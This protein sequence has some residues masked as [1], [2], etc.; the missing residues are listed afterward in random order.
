LLARF[1]AGQK[2]A[3]NQPTFINFFLLL[4]A[5]SI[6]PQPFYH[7]LTQIVLWLALLATVVSGADYAQQGA[8]FIK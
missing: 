6:W 4:A 7:T 8:K 3:K 1:S 5:L 2:Y